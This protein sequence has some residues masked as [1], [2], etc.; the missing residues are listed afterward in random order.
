MSKFCENCGAEMEDNQTVCPN[1][2]N[3]AEEVKAEE[4]KVEETVET[5]DTTDTTT[6]KKS[7]MSSE[8]L[9]KYGIIGGIALAVIVVLAIIINILSSGWKKPIDN[10]FKGMQKGD[11]KTYEK[12]YPDFINEKRDLDDDDMEKMHD[13]L[14]DEYGEKIKISYKVTKN[15]K[16]KK[17][18]LKKV[19]DYISKYYDEDVK[20]SAGK[21]VKIKATIKGKDDSDT[22]TNKMYVYKINGKWKILD[23]SPSTAKDYLKSHEDDDE[24]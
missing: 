9:K 24:D 6:T 3:G 11:L 10:Y 4:V 21:E 14:E 15:E 23:V 7:A 19:Q 5:T 18:D 2:G 12:A 20:V 16:I 1:C 13:N 17:D 22:N 8:N